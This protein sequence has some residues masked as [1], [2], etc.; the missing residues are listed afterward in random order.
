MDQVKSAA[1]STADERDPGMPWTNG[2]PSLHYQIS[3]EG[4]P[5]IFLHE[6]GGSSYSWEST[7]TRLATAMRKIRYDQRNA[8]LSERSAAP[9]DLYDQIADLEQ[10]VAA[11]DAHSPVVLA[12]IAASATIAAGYALKHPSRV[13]ALIFAAPA[14]GL[15]PEQRAPTQARA[16]ATAKAGMRSIIDTAMERMYPPSLRRADFETYRARFLAADPVG[17][18]SA[19]IAF[20]DA[21]VPLGEL[22]VPT[23]LLA[24]AHDIRPIE[25]IEQ[26]RQ[27]IP[28]ARMIV[29][30]EAGHVLP[31]QAPDEAAAAIDSFLHSL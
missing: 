15:N 25:A 1:D 20:A 16:E 9:F 26:A 19:T 7:A 17:F 10:I 31:H 13:S 30:E 29:I 18:A 28:G 12:T 2:N 11:M 21:Q 8:G 14:F 4:P 3:G 24:G 6:I 5:L 27:D 22:K 23:L